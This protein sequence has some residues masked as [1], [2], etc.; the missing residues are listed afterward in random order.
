MWNSGNQEQ[1]N[2]HT[3]ISSEEVPMKFNWRNCLVIY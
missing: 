1:K 3:Q 2:G